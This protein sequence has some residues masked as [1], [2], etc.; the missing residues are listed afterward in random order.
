[1]I[2]YF[3]MIKKLFE[4]IEAKMIA[5]YVATTVIL[6][7]SFWAG[8][9][10]GAEFVVLLVIA[11]VL[12][13]IVGLIF[14]VAWNL[15][16]STWAP[17]LMVM[18]AITAIGLSISAFFVATGITPSRFWGL[19]LL[20]MLAYKTWQAM[21]G[22]VFKSRAAY[23]SFFTLFTVL[24]IIATIVVGVSAFVNGPLTWQ[25]FY[26]LVIC[27]FYSCGQIALRKK[28]ET[29]E[30][31]WK[32]AAIAFLTGFVFIFILIVVLILTILS[33]DGSGMGDL[34]SGITLDGPSGRGKKKNQN[35]PDGG[36]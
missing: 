33:Q 34:F 22:R 19:C 13:I 14:L 2:V 36:R 29:N 6:Y 27:F 21:L 26:A 32:S 5:L 12:V 16:K 28:A 4:N 24:E 35:P 30:N 15:K 8:W 25:V 20:I 18:A 9:Y 11:V 3:H 1:M 17:M 7:G 31:F 10:S 23:Y